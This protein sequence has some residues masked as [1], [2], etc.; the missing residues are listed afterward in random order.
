[1]SFLL[2]SESEAQRSDKPPDPRPHPWGSA[3]FSAR[4]SPRADF[5][6][7]FQTEIEDHMDDQDANAGQ[8]ATEDR[9]TWH[10]KQW[11]AWD[12]R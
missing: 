11:D 8:D 7:A 6:G 3:L 9:D 2:S 12:D 1:M 4:F 5:A 10:E